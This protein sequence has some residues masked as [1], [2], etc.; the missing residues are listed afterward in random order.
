[1][2]YD[3]P[4]P[5]DGPIGFGVRFVGTCRSWVKL[6]IFSTGAV[7]A[8]RLGVGMPIRWLHNGNVSA[9]CNNLSHA[10]W[11]RWQDGQATTIGKED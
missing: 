9:Q 6:D 10:K 4:E 11:S 1:M 7:D 2:G 3:S 8:E 5:F